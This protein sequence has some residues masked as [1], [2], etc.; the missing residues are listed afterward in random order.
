MKTRKCLEMILQESKSRSWKSG[1][2]PSERE[3]RAA[4]TQKDDVPVGASIAASGL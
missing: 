3:K 1:E 2:R 4:R